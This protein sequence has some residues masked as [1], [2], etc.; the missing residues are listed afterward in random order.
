MATFFALVKRDYEKFTEAD[1]APLLEPE[2][3]RARELYTAGAFRQM[4]SR[5]DLPGAAILIEAASLEEAKGFMAS[6]PLA[7]K[8]MLKY[9]VM[10]LSP[11]RGFGPRK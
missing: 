2:A 11:Y 8:G 1:F 6:L 7:E 10:P 5:G 9:E 3:E 4:W